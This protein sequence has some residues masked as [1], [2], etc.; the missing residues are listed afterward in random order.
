MEQY[1]NEMDHL[2]WTQEGK[3][4]LIRRVKTNAEQV[5]PVRHCLSM[6]KY[7]LVAAMICLFSVSAYATGILQSATDVLAPILG[8]TPVQT[9]I[10]E[11]I[12]RPIGASDTSDG[13]TIS[14]DAIIGDSNNVC[15]VYSIENGDGTPFVLP[16]GISPQD[17]FFAGNSGTEFPFTAGGINGSIG[18]QDNNETDG[19]LQIVEMLSSEKRLP[20]GKNVT[21]NFSQLSYFNTDGKVVPLSDGKWKL[22]YALNFENVGIIIPVEKQFTRDSLTFTVNKIMIS[23]IAIKANYTVNGIPNWSNSK[24]GKMPEQDQ[25]EMNKF[26]EGIELIITKSDGTTIDLTESSGGGL[27]HEKDV[28]FGYKGTVLDEI[29]PLNEIVSVTVGDIVIDINN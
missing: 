8:A 21:A 4:N 3:E 16:N 23:P 12:G 10:I 2:H 5:Q 27:S 26:L 28:T 9:E 22:R 25:K 18:V 13:I 20:L 15:V 6:G 7:A 17:V 1:K 29:I 14:A 19:I 11:K 24:S